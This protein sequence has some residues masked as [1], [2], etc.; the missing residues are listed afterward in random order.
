MTLKLIVALFILWRIVRY[1]RRRGRAR[2]SVL[3]ARKHWALLLAHPYVE[4]TEFSRFSDADASRVGDDTRRFLRAQML[5]QMELRTD[6]TDDDARAHLAR[7]LE[8]QW[9]RADLHALHADDEPRAA[10][11]FACARMAF[12]ARAAML[13]GWA[14][15]DVAWR[16]LLLNAQRAQDCFDGWED[17][18]RAY[19]A[20]R[21][22][23]VT[24]FRAD[25]LG[26]AVDEAAVQRWLAPADGAWG[27]A[28]WPG[29]A[30]F[31]PEPVVRLR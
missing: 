10:L 11:A 16:V 3:S 19:V 8:T 15:P 6:A 1:L 2:A 14:E 25:P 27:R 12:F 26:R 4:A 18:G 29:L 7:V 5:H 9:F 24:A 30:T 17:F 23:W 22:Q 20:G 21:K 31:D 28:A 13:M